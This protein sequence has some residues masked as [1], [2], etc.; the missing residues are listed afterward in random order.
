MM[1]PIK[2]AQGNIVGQR[3]ATLDDIMGMSRPASAPAPAPEPEPNNV[4]PTVCIGCHGPGQHECGLSLDE[5][6]CAAEP[7]P[8]PVTE[9]FTLP[10]MEPERNNVHPVEHIIDPC[11]TCME[12]ITNCRTC[13]FNADEPVMQ[14]V[15]TPPAVQSVQ[16]P[17]MQY[18]PAPAAEPATAPVPDPE[19]E[20]LKAEAAAAAKEEQIR[21]ASEKY[22]AMAD[23]VDALHVEKAALYKKYSSIDGLISDMCA[24][25]HEM[26]ENIKPRLILKKKVTRKEIVDQIRRGCRAIGEVQVNY[27]PDATGEKFRFVNGQIMMYQHRRPVEDE[28]YVDFVSK[29]HGD[30]EAMI[31][32]PAMRAGFH[33][34]ITFVIA[35]R[36]RIKDDDGNVT[37]TEATIKFAKPRDIWIFNAS[38]LEKI[39]DVEAIRLKPDHYGQTNV[40]LLDYDGDIKRNADLTRGVVDQIKPE[41]DEA[42]IARNKQVMDSGNLVKEIKEV[43]DKHLGIWL[44]LRN[45]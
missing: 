16:T 15:Q 33:T 4:E 2:D 39:V 45:L 3:K 25:L 17:V 5:M 26:D 38:D 34:F 43:A 10:K 14:Y 22:Q 12:S 31:R 42:I 21:R 32:D 30:I 9:S 35:N 36:H 19:A 44:A 41:L 24:P 28:G 13:R 20:R 23:K 18:T 29:Y 7:A 8:E 37:V 1:I 6:R 27:H 11:A 40:L